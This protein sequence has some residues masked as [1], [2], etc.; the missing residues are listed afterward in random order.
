MLLK[1]LQSVTVERRGSHL[2]GAFDLHE[3]AVDQARDIGMLTALSV[4]GARKYM[5]AAKADEAR[6]T[7]LAIAASYSKAWTPAPGARGLR[8]L[9]SL[10][11]VPAVVP[12]GAKYLAAPGEWKA[13]QAI[14]FKVDGP[15]YYQYEVRAAKDGRSADII[16][17]G[18]LDADGK[19]SEFRLHLS[20]GKDKLAVSENIEEHDPEE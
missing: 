17:K 13:W 2:S 14:N 18:D 3:G 19:Q 16:A 12:K 20:Q 6:S 11:P 10:P 8:K 15:Q 5:V 4:Y 1:L 7:L 9:V